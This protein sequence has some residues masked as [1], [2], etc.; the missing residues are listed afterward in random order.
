MGY[1]SLKFTNRNSWDRKE[2]L[3]WKHPEYMVN[4]YPYLPEA[5]ALGWEI[6]LC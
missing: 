4:M 3:S 5:C 6:N 1:S 2:T